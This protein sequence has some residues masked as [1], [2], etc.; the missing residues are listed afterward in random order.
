MARGVVPPQSGWES[1]GAGGRILPRLSHT[2][3]YQA[4]YSN[5]QRLIHP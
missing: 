4:I 1:L 2:K 5:C 3:L